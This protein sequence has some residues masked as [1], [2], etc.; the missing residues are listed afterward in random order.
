M[1]T[2]DQLIEMD[3]ADDMYLGN[4]NLGNGFGY[5]TSSTSNGAGSTSTNG[6]SNGLNLFAN[7][8]GAAASSSSC[9]PSSSSSHIQAL[10]AAAK[11]GAS[12]STR[13]NN[14]RQAIARVTL[15]G[16]KLYEDSVVEREEFVRLVIQ[17]LRDVGY[18]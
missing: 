1:A 5:A 12:K 4:G 2:R 15:P 14:E 16:T 6:T 9:Y 7:G 11:N 13:D 3:D 17:S 8:N 10:K 18:V